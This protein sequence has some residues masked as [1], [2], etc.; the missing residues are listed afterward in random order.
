MRRKILRAG[1][2]VL[3]PVLA[4]G[5]LPL[6]AAVGWI[7]AYER[8]AW[9]SP[10]ALSPARMGV[11]VRPCKTSSTINRETIAV[12]SG[13]V[14]FDRHRDPVDSRQNVAKQRRM[15]PNHFGERQK[16]LRCHTG[17]AATE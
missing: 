2:A 1:I 17:S 13:A 8:G 16:A 3:V 6:A 11:R 4:A 15:R 5:F 10:W 7:P 9:S 12:Y 14:E